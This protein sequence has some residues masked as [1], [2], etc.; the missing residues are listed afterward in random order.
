MMRW[1][2][3]I[4]DFNIKLEHIEGK[5][6]SSADDLSRQIYPNSNLKNDTDI[7]IS[8]VNKIELKK[9]TIKLGKSLVSSQISD[10]YGQKLKNKLENI[11][12]SVV[13]NYKVQND[14]LYKTIHTEIR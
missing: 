9:E 12:K 2:L 4:Q 13:D 14:F 5:K 8:A 3:S 7:I 10:G 6:N 11:D 1:S